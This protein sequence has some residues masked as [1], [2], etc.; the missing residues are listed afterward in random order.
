M[1]DDSTATAP[2]ASEAASDAAGTVLERADALAAHSEEPG[3]LTP[4]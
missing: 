3:R 2:A 1:P 4:G